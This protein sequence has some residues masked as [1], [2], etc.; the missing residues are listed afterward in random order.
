[1]VALMGTHSTT[2]FE[3]T[4]PRHLFTHLLVL[5][6]RLQVQLPIRAHTVRQQRLSVTQP[7]TQV[8]HLTV[9][10]PPLLDGTVESPAA[11]NVIKRLR[12][13]K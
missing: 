2:T 4:P 5:S 3:F 9:E 7:L 11:E 10:L 13:K 1:M 8:V 12:N 6:G